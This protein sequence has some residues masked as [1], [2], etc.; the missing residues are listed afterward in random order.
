MEMCAVCGVEQVS[1]A[2][3]KEDRKGVQRKSGSQL[4]IQPMCIF[5]FPTWLE[6]QVGLSKM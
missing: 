2:E 3:G 6:Y 5:N 1:R 4:M